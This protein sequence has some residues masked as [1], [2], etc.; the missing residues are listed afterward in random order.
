MG[1]PWRKWNI[2]LAWNKYFCRRDEVITKNRSLTKK[3]YLDKIKSSIGRPL[4]DKFFWGKRLDNFWTRQ[5]KNFFK[6]NLCFFKRLD[7]TRTKNAIWSYITLKWY[8]YFI[9]QLWYRGFNFIKN[10]RIKRN[11]CIKGQ[12]IAG[13]KASV[14]RLQYI[15]RFC[16]TKDRWKWFSQTFS[17]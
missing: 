14:I 12:I 17:Y 7:L 1:Q 15:W 16:G 9:C 5:A 3:R 4:L 2:C 8:D 11:G 13:F 6:R 10:E